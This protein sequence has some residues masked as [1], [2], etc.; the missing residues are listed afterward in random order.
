MIRSKTR[1]QKLF[2]LTYQFLLVRACA[3]REAPVAFSKFDM[4]P[5]PGIFT[6]GLL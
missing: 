4:L 1:S 5:P 3:S 6:V 2:S